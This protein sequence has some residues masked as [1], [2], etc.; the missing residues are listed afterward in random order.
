MVLGAI[1]MVKD[2]LRATETVWVIKDHQQSWM[3]P[4]GE[5]VKCQKLFLRN[6]ERL[7]A[8]EKDFPSK[9]EMDIQTSNGCPVNFTFRDL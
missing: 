2:S 5:M 1:E 3:V 4:V 8:K 7:E 6:S 9:K